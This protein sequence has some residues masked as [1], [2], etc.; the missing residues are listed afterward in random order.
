MAG[1]Q[2]ESLQVLWLPE[3]VADDVCAP[4]LEHSK[5]AQHLPQ[6][7]VHR[8]HGQPVPP[9]QWSLLASHVA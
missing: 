3:Q 9:S 2:L 8:P 5:A 6:V 7:L 1:L 4:S